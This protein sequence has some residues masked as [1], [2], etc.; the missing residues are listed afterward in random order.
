M[1]DRKHLRLLVSFDRNRQLLPRFSSL[2]WLKVPRVPYY[3]QHF[4][5]Q[6]AHVTWPWNGIISPIQ[7]IQR[8]AGTNASHSSRGYSP[9][10]YIPHA[11]EEILYSHLIPPKSA[12][13]A[14]AGRSHLSY[15]ITYLGGG[16]R[17]ILSF[18]IHPPSSLCVAL[19]PINP[20]NP[21]NHP[22]VEP[23]SPSPQVKANINP[24]RGIKSRR[25]EN[26]CQIANIKKV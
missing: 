1:F 21:T 20:S 13:V 4:P 5:H 23:N 24:F 18:P 9:V 10:S 12:P 26:R 14:P 17:V 25:L 19:I 15:I 16:Q 8:A 2:Y 3:A 22:P 6:E 7:I 11:M